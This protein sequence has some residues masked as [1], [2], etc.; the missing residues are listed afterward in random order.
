MTNTLGEVHVLVFRGPLFYN[1]VHKEFLVY[2]LEDSI[3]KVAPPKE[4]NIP[5]PNLFKVACV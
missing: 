3:I 5:T 2:P 1:Q 4:V